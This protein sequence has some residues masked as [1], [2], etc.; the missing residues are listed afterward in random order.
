M[1]VFFKSIFVFVSPVVFGIII[2]F[3]SSALLSKSIIKNSNQY[4]IDKNIDL[5]FLG[6]SHMTFAIIDSL[7]PKSS[8]QATIA[9][10]YYYTFQKL[11]FIVQ[12]NNIKKVVLAVGYHNI[13]DYYDHLINGNLSTVFPKKIFFSLD[14]LE[15]LRVLN[16]NKNKL[17]LVLNEIVNSAFSKFSDLDSK[18]RIYRFSDGYYNTLTDQMAL[19]ESVQKRVKSQFF[20]NEHQKNNYSNFNI[21]YL[22]KIIKFCFKNDI[23]IILIKT[24]LHS[25]Y[26]NLVPNDFKSKLNKIIFESNAKLINLE[27]L[28]L[29]D[30]C[31]ANDGDH[32]TIKG[33]KLLTDRLIK[34]LK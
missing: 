21:K 27:K 1:K 11:K 10:P 30:S 14:F 15:K 2:L 12:N 18:N 24:P 22:K 29:S 17:F 6:D 16:W 9:E 13:S 28:P 7:I 19:L 33:A 3:I 8:N 4:E 23:E 20:S 5:I 34:I 31:F 32:L 26:L 25:N